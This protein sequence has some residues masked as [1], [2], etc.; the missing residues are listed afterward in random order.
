MKKERKNVSSIYYL[1]SFIPVQ[2]NN[3]MIIISPLGPLL[4][5]FPPGTVIVSASSDCNEMN[6][7]LWRNTS[8]LCGASVL[9]L[10]WM[11]ARTSGSSAALWRPTVPLRSASKEEESF[12]EEAQPH[13]VAS[14][15]LWKRKFTL[16]LLYHVKVGDISVLW[17][18]EDEEVQ[19]EAKFRLRPSGIISDRLG[20]SW[21]VSGHLK[22]SRVILDY[23]GSEL[24]WVVLGH[25]GWSQVVLGCLR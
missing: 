22:L 25:L 15:R 13:A 6:R 19:N 4:M 8:A 14:M 12:R 24:S 23:L 3:Y 21:A 18:R 17:R 10:K 5:S 16:I 9:V 7:H 20:S 2:G 11:L 1:Y